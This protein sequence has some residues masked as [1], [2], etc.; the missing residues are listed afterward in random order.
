MWKSSKCAFGHTQ[1][2]TNCQCPPSSGVCWSIPVAVVN[3]ILG[4]YGNSL[5]VEFHSCPIVLNPHL[6]I[7]YREKHNYLPEECI[8][9]STALNHRPIWRER[10][11]RLS[12]VQTIYREGPTI[13]FESLSLCLFLL[14]EGICGCVYIHVAGVWMLQQTVNTFETN[15]WPHSPSYKADVLNLPSAS[16]RQKSLV[17][18]EWQLG[19]GRRSRHWRRSP[20]IGLQLGK[21]Q[22]LRNGNDWTQLSLWPSSKMG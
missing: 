7:P 8:G 2:V 22:M 4:V 16:Q 20:G 15:Y 9:L 21:H 1:C 17:T 12:N 6:I 19:S 11:L 10:Y 3:C 18:F 14:S 5:W 13:S